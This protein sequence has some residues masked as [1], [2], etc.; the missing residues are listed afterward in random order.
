M[1]M[2]I[3]ENLTEQLKLKTA[4]FDTNVLSTIKKYTKNLDVR[5]FLSTL[6]KQKCSVCVNDLIRLE[7]LRD[8]NKH[9]ELTERKKY[10]AALCAEVSLSISQQT[11][12]DAMLLSYIH[13]RHKNKGIEFVDLMT[14]ALLKNYSHN[15]GLV[16]VT[17][18]HKDF[19]LSVHDRI[20]SIVLDLGKDLATLGFYRINME[21]WNKEV[22]DLL[23]DETWNSDK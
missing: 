20:G 3:N 2:V 6:N 11:Y 4:L 17:A 9:G 13:V 8:A 7:F 18:N 23:K 14:S 22:I 1:N 15:Q 5:Y 19:P 21:K 12:S 16:L 10:L